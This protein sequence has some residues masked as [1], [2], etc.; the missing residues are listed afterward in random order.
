M[1]DVRDVMWVAHARMVRSFDLAR[2]HV[3]FLS[4][5]II[6]VV[7]VLTDVNE[8]R[9]RCHGAMVQV[10]AASHAKCLKD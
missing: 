1:R 4:Q 10:T 3:L 5:L 8:P 6:P 7:C 2:R 9:P